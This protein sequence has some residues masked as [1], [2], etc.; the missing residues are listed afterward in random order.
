MK[1]IIIYAILIIFC[2]LL[3]ATVFRGLA[4]V[5][6][7]PNLLIILCASLGFMRGEITGLVVGFF[8]GLLI[9]VFFG[10]VIGLYA[11]LYMHMGYLNGKFSG[12]YYP[13]NLKLPLV[14]IISSNLLLSLA[15]YLLLFVMRGR[16]D[17]AFYLKNVIAPEVIYTMLL[18][19]LLYPLLLWIEKLLGRESGVTMK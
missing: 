5:G 12:K 3:Q 11:L 7:V 10:N 16:F 14:L 8:C 1:R 9:D 17:F 2:F 19:L 4:F 15:S 6:I 13:E 18:A